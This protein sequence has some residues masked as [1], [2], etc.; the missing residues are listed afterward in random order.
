[1]EGGRIVTF[2]YRN[3]KYHLNHIIKVSFIDDMNQPSSY[4]MRRAFHPCV[5]F[6][7]NP[8]FQSNHEENIKQTQTEGYSTKHLARKPQNSQGHDKQGKTDICHRP[9]ETWQL[10]A[11]DILDRLLVQKEDVGGSEEVWGVH[12]GEIQV[13]SGVQLVP[14]LISMFPQILSS[15]LA[16]QFSVNLTLLQN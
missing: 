11:M 2:Q 8:W 12:T 14:M 1:M 15:T 6:P 13:K 10:D 3:G 16:L 4:A 7:P 9:D 5:L